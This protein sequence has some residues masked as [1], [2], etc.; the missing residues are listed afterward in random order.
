LPANS[1]EMT[2]KKIFRFHAVRVFD[3][4]KKIKNYESNKSSRTWRSG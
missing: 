1:H 4:G 3:S 2:Q